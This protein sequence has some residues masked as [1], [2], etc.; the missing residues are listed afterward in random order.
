MPPARKKKA[1]VR[2]APFPP[3]EDACLDED[4]H[5]MSPETPAVDHQSIREEQKHMNLLNTYSEAAEWDDDHSEVKEEVR[6]RSGHLPFGR[7]YFQL[8]DCNP[9]KHGSF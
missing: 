4:T 8:Q 6:Y 7:R 1:A 3:Q 5:R 9:V 2:T